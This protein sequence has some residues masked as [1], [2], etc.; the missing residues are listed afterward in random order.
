MADEIE[1]MRSR[2]NN[3]LDSMKLKKKGNHQLFSREEYNTFVAKVMETKLKTCG[4]TPEDYQRV[5]RY[6]IVNIGSV[7]KLIVPVGNEK[8]PVVYYTYLEENFQIIH[9]IH[10]SI[11]HGGRMRM[12]E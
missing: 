1:P 5:A 6:D 12:N 11:G 3:Y 10:I 9:D 7:P 2:F 8:D 4:K